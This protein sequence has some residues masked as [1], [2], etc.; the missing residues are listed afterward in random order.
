MMMMMSE[1]NDDDDKIMMMR[2]VMRMMMMV[3]IPMAACP[4]FRASTICCHHRMRRG[5]G[6]GDELCDALNKIS[7]VIQQLCKSIHPS[8]YP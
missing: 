8:I 4:I 7:Y 5:R 2:T 3:K 6:R 1:D